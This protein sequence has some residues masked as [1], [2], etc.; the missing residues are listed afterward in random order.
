MELFEQT[1]TFADRAESQSLHGVFGRLSRALSLF[2]SHQMNNTIPADDNDKA[3]LQEAKMI[4]GNPSGLPDGSA[5]Y[6]IILN[7]LGF[8]TTDENFFGAGRET[9][10]IVLK[11]VEISNLHAKP[12][13]IAALMTEEK[14]FIQG[15]ARDLLH[16]YDITSDQMRSLGASYY[17]GN[18]LKQ[19]L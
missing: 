9:E 3:L 8:P 11:N 12:I 18:F 14:A 13:E 15:P 19:R 1:I 16:I 4:F 7:R 2:R 10:N 5:V 6:G 17:K